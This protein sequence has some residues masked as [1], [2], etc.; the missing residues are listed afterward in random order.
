VKVWIA[1]L[2][3]LS[4]F[5][6]VRANGAISDGV[7]QGQTEGILQTVENGKLAAAGDKLLVTSVDHG[8]PVEMIF[9]VARG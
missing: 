7:L 2:V 9:T 5:V 6:S 1:V 3:F 8:A 4:I